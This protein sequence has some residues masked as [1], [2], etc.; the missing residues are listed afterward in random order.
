MKAHDKSIAL[1]IKIKIEIITTLTIS[2]DGYI[3]LWNAKLECIFSLKIP[4][5]VKIVWNMHE[6]E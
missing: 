2:I 5:L 1:A 3:R 6:I 4:S